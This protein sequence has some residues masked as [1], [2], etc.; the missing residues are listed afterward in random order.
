MT[1]TVSAGAVVKNQEIRLP[2]QGIIAGRATFDDGE[3]VTRGVVNLLR[4]GYGPKG[5]E[6]RAGTRAQTNDQGEFVIGQL[7]AGKYY[8]V[9]GPGPRNSTLSANISDRRTFYPRARNFETAV[10]IGT[11]GTLRSAVLFDNYRVLISGGN[12][13]GTP[14]PGTFGIL[15]RMWM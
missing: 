8:V 2:P 6:L 11:R 4:I 9:V 1:V 12:E 13:G 7:A 5:K 3:P 14:G 10:P 15:V